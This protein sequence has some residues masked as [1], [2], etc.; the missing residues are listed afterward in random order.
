MHRGFD[1]RHLRSCKVPEA[2]GL[3]AKGATSESKLPIHA[4]NS[5]LSKATRIWE[6]SG[7]QTQKRTPGPRCN[8]RGGSKEPDNSKP[9]DN[10]VG[11][12]HSHNCDSLHSNR[13]SS[14]VRRSNRDGSVFD[15]RP[16]PE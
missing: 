3:L 16:G 6:V 15:R 4:G 7:I 2:D 5:D 12:T 8:K 1:P 10:T 11:N 13:D 9:A 14:H